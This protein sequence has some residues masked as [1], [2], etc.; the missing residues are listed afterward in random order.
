MLVALDRVR[1]DLA[2]DPAAARQRHR[3]RDAATAARLFLVS[4]FVGSFL[5]AGVGA[6]AAR[7]YGLSRESRQ[8]Q[9]G[10]SPRSPST[11]CWA[12][13][14]IVVMGAGRRGWRGR[15]R[16]R[17]T[18]ACSCADRRR[19]PSACVGGRSGPTDWLRWVIPDRIAH[20]TP[21]ARRVLRFARRASAATATGRS[22]AGPRDGAGRCVVQVLRIPQA[23][24]SASAWA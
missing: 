10:A 12:C 9:R 23:Y 14:R 20:G 15:Q 21:V 11:A 8:R 7:A 24:C 18:G 2:L 4:S 1:D 17:P 16:V 5:P 3:D 6:D 22:V 13:C 19:W